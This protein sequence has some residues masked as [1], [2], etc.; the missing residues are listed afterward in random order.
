[1]SQA[2]SP[3]DQSTL[4]MCPQHHQ[5]H[6]QHCATAQ[7]RPYPD[8][9]P[10]DTHQS[11]WNGRHLIIEGPWQLLMAPNSITQPYLEAKGSCPSRDSTRVPV[12]LGNP[13]QATT[14]HSLLSPPPHLS[15]PQ[16]PCPTGT[17][18]QKS[19]PTIGIITSYTSLLP[20]DSTQH[21]LPPTSWVGLVCWWFLRASSTSRWST[22]SSRLQ[23]IS[24]GK[25]I[26][27]R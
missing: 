7:L 5:P 23:A 12:H 17:S 1:M 2:V 16:L 26:K 3:L 20:Q 24:P 19:S 4:L 27:V 25:E 15:F 6:H 22:T 14:H 13:C 10:R 8:P 9:T 18:S 21:H 11:P